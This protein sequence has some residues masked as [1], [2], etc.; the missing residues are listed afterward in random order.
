MIGHEQGVQ[1]VFIAVQCLVSAD[2]ADSDDIPSVLQ[3]AARNND[4]L[5]FKNDISFRPVDD[6]GLGQLALLGLKVNLQVFGSSFT[7]E[8]NLLIESDGF[9]LFFWNVERQVVRNLTEMTGTVLGKCLRH[10]V[11]LIAF[12]TEI[13]LYSTN[14]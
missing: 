12:V 5:V 2:A 7:V 11:S 8:D 14:I 9:L 1:I 4:V 13:S 6:N 3:I 10:P